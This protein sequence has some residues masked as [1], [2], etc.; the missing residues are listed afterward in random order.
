MRRSLLRAG[1]LPNKPILATRG[2]CDGKTS[3]PPTPKPDK[4]AALR[5]RFDR[6]I[7]RTPGFLRPTVTGLRY[8][9]ISHTIAFFFLHEF[10]AIVPLFGL[11]GAF[12][13]CHWLPP[14]FAE[15]AWIAAAVEK[16]ARYFRKKGWI[17]DKEEREIE[18]ETT[19]GKA[20]RF[21]EQKTA[22]S[23]SGWFSNGE[24]RTRWVVEFATAYAIV[25]VL[26]PARIF[27]SVWGAPWF[28]RV[29][30]TPAANLTKFLW[31][32]IIRPS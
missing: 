29:A 20:R 12:H 6:F 2:L 8:A 22:V 10:T 27:V 9:P 7:E 1:R 15:G 17:T 25:K 11:A 19:E 18:V 32:R 4:K 3:Q 26:L 24:N 21:E 13:Y 31:Q 28:A 16:F 5:S 30:V 14:Y 23:I